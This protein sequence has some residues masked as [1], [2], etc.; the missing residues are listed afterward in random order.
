MHHPLDYARVVQRIG[1][2]PAEDLY[3][4]TL[5]DLLPAATIMVVTVTATTT[6][7][8]LLGPE[9]LA[10]VQQ[11]C[12]LALQLENDKMQVGLRG[13]GFLLSAVEPKFAIAHH[14]RPI[15]SLCFM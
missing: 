11:G 4:V 2:R 12:E 10:R 7:G 3:Q 9:A 8:K 13:V 15:K 5:D 14:G 1:G 6:S